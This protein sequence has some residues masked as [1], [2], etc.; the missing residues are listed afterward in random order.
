VPAGISFTS[1]LE[2]LVECAGWRNELENRSLAVLQGLAPLLAGRAL[3]RPEPQDPRTRRWRR[4]R[5]QASNQLRC[6][7]DDS[8]KQLDKEKRSFGQQWVD[9]WR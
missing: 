1:S 5:G 7:T 6:S 9:R 8:S 3:M 2:A 4:F